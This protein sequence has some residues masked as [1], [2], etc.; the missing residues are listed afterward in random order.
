MRKSDPESGVVASASRISKVETD[1][2]AAIRCSYSVRS[3]DCSVAS[4][5]ILGYIGRIENIWTI[6]KWGSIPQFSQ[7]LFDDASLVHWP[8]DSDSDSRKSK[9]GIGDRLGNKRQLMAPDSQSISA[10]LRLETISFEFTIIWTRLWMS[11]GSQQIDSSIQNR[12]LVI[13]RVSRF[14]ILHFV[15]HEV[16]RRRDR[17]MLNGLRITLPVVTFSAAQPLHRWLPEFALAGDETSTRPVRFAIHP[18][19][20]VPMWS[21]SYCQSSDA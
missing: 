2:N 21:H 8:C 1:R 4:T 14:S 10:E 5:A 20:D 15:G 3:I 6:S 19:Q 9:I 7:N 18:L 16:L 17:H 12:S 11:S 13:Q